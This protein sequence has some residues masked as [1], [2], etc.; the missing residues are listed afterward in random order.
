MQLLLKVLGAGF[1]GVVETAQLMP[2]SVFVTNITFISSPL[3]KFGRK[4][5]KELQMVIKEVEEVG[6]KDASENR[7]MAAHS[8]GTMCAIVYSA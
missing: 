3:F 1:S 4:N 6:V 5:V 8:T 7:A 2:P